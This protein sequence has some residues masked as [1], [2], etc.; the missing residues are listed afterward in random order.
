MHIQCTWCYNNYVQSTQFV[1]CLLGNTWMYDT[2]THQY[3][4]VDYST[5]HNSK[6]VHGIIIDNGHSWL[7][8][9]IVVDN[10]MWMTTM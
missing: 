2:M 6:Q 1:T 8:N 10:V 4:Y 9:V 3:L 7:L 5:G